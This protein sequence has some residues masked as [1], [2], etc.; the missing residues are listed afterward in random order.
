M[1]D[2]IIV[3]E[4]LVV[5]ERAQRGA[6]FRSAAV[7]CATAW[8]GVVPWLVSATSIR[9]RMP[10]SHALIHLG[11]GR[12]SRRVSQH[13]PVKAAPTLRSPAPSAPR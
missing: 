3:L 2:E 4:A 13:R 10:A 8:G 7:A 6:I 9:G 11:Y 1:A 5:G 12:K